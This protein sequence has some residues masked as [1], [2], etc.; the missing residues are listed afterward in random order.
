MPV[1]IRVAEHNAERVNTIYIAKSKQHLFEYSC[2]GEHRK[3]EELLFTSDS[4]VVGGE[5]GHVLPSYN[6][7]VYAIYKAYSHHHHI[8]IRPEDVWFSIL[9]Q[10]S[11]YINANAERLRS[12]FVSHEGKKDIRVD[13]AGDLESFNVPDLISE[14]IKKIQGHVTDKDLV[15]WVMPSFSTTTA[16]D[17]VVASVILLGTM[18]K[19]FEYGGGFCCGLPSVTLLGE[20]KDWETILKKIDKLD[21]WGPE[22]QGFAGMLRPVLR[23]SIETFSDPFGSSVR[24]FWA[25]C[26]HVTSGSGSDTIS[27]WASVFCYWTEKGTCLRGFGAQLGREY[28]LDGVTYHGVKLE[29]VPSAFVSF[30]VTLE[31]MGT[32]HPVSIVAGLVGMGVEIDTLQPR[33][34]WFLYKRGNGLDELGFD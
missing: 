13:V 20:R 26:M 12:H 6:G 2:P 3:S 29:N 21:A 5:L 19:Y 28:S 17:E 30:P 25:H 34:G 1:T 24:D 14:L 8:T 23:K 9:T 31:V 27:G 11:F 10:V 32:P 4:V 33:S 7:L 15:S 16:T 18:E 22:A